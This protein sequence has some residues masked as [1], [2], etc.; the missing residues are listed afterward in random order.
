MKWV[1]PFLLLRVDSYLQVQSGPPYL[2]YQK[3]K[4]QTVKNV[5]VAHVSAYHAYPYSFSPINTWALP[6]DQTCRYPHRY[7]Q[8]W[9]W[10][11]HWYI[12]P[13]RSVSVHLNLYPSCHSPDT[14]PS[15][16]CCGPVELG[17]FHIHLLWGSLVKQGIGVSHALR[18]DVQWK[19]LLCCS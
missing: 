2:A 10:L 17:F 15:I 9:R 7:Y 14:H 3:Q 16:I 18:W 1:H 4:E 12:C 5:S 13:I 8:G 11:W 19:G 6:L